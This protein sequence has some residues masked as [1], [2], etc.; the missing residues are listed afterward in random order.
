MSV[1]S[2]SWPPPG[3]DLR[4]TAAAAAVGAALV[5]LSFLLLAVGAFEDSRIVD[6]PVYSRYG[7]AVLDGKV[8]YRDFS[9]E[10]PPG[11]LPAF[12]LPALA[13]AGEFDLAFGILVGLLSVVSVALVAVALGRLGAGPA[14]LYGGVVLA[15]LAPLLL[16]TLVL[17]RYDAWPAALSVAAIAAIVSGRH[18]LAL[19]VLAAAVTAKLYPAVLLPLFLA[20]TAARKGGREAAVSLAVFA[21]VLAAVLLPFAAAS[22]D[23]LGA[24]FE[25][26]TERPLQVESL[27]S[28]LVLAA[29]QAGSYEPTVVSSFGSQ[30]LFGELPDA[31]ATV[32]T[33]LQALAILAI[34]ALFLPRRASSEALVAAAA[35]AVAALVAFGK[36]LSPQFLLWLVPLVP[37]AGGGLGLAAGALLAA[38]LLLTHLWFPS[39]YWELVAFEAGPVW[40]LVARN[41]CLLGL[42]AVLAA[43]TARARAR[44]RTA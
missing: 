12:V 39:R 18:R 44:S 10:Y 41:V 32:Q 31:L 2:A 16:G 24:S 29:G 22:A 38:A 40:L 14:R 42:V 20:A 17:S 37:L 23:G 30:N 26:Q 8:P 21:A 27:G 34:W 6:T 35:A 33:I 3:L 43:V 19:A 25:R 11:A 15:G 7:E 28:S 13:P 5:G 36:V 1:W 9:L 4:R